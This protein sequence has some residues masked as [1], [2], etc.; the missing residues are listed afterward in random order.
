MLW[1]KSI[2]CFAPLLLTCHPLS[3]LPIAKISNVQILSQVLRVCQPGVGANCLLIVLINPTNV[4]S[5]IPQRLTEGSCAGRINQLP[6]VN[7]AIIAKTTKAA[8]IFS[9][10]VMAPFCPISSMILMTI[11]LQTKPYQW[12]RL[13]RW[14]NHSVR[15]NVR[16]NPIPIA[17]HATSGFINGNISGASKTPVILLLRLR[18]PRHNVN[19]NRLATHKLDIQYSNQGTH[20]SA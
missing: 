20:A 7:H 14:I 1:P 5:H 17:H 12:R 3:C 13:R 16:T 6:A 19:H 2:R 9:A 15:L 8:T 10:N 4:P 18:G 11:C